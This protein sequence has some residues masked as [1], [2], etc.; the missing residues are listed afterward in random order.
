MSGA[1]ESSFAHAMSNMVLKAQTFG[2][3]IRGMGKAILTS[4]VDII[5]QLIARWAMMEATKFAISQ[6][7]MGA[8]FAA[9]MGLL[10]AETAAKVAAHEAETPIKAAE[11]VGL[12]NMAAIGSFASQAGIPVVGPALGAA[13]MASTYA[14]L[15]PLIPL[16]SASGGF[17]IPDGVNPLTQLH[18]KEMVLPA[19]IADPLRENLKNG[20]MGGGGMTVN[21]TAMDAKGVKAFMMDNQDALMAAMKKANRNFK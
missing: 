9:D 11:A 17:D 14:T 7:W 20:S 10:S 19:H 12:V 15:T 5:A 16:A 21:I 8:K 4:F 1:I 3:A 6:G 18:T 2:Q 13:A